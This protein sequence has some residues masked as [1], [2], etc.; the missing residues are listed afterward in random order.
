MKN[1]KI[2]AGIAFLIVFIFLS[3]IFITGILLYKPDSRGS[4][5]QNSSTYPGGSIILN[6]T[7][8]S[9]HNNVNDCWLLIN[10]KIY[11]VTSFISSHLGNS[12]TILVNCGKESTQQFDSRGGTGSHS[13]TAQSL[14]EQYYIGDFGQTI[15][16]DELQN[17]T[18]GLQNVNIL[19]IGNGQDDEFDN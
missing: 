11:D 9:K 5:T 15:G 4:T 10:N 8:I 13:S 12:Q 7:E 17:K 16:T 14:L 18:S 3:I 2:L 19:Q 1:T 6:M